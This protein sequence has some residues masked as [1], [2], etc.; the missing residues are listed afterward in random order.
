MK[1]AWER[2]ALATEQACDIVMDRSRLA[3]LCILS[4]LAFNVGLL[5]RRSKMWNA[6]TLRKSLDELALSPLPKLRN[7]AKTWTTLADLAQRVSGKMQAV[8]GA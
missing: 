3:N 2:I 8:G 5:S 1:E 7:S 6:L 4:A